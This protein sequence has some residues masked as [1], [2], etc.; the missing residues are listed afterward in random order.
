[1]NALYYVIVGILAIFLLKI[2]ISLTGIVL[3]VLL[4]VLLAGIIGYIIVVFIN[5][6]K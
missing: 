1:M 5:N 3:T 6:I 4:Y 2:I